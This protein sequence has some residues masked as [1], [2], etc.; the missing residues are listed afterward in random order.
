MESPGINNRCSCPYLELT[1][2]VIYDRL[3]LYDRLWYFKGKNDI[4]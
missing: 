2:Y 3:W 1:R 4:L